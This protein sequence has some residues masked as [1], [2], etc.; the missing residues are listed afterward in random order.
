MSRE[1]E[2]KVAIVTG[3]A[4]GI[5]K[6]IAHAFGVTPVPTLSSTIPAGGR[7]ATKET[8]GSPSSSRQRSA[9]RDGVHLRRLVASA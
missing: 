5:G 2:G 6:A 9:S 7:S 1:L 4:T 3:A 8:P